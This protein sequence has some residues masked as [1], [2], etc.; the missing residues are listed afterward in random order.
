MQK[1][2][3]IGAR[4]F[5]RDIYY[6]A[7]QCN[8]YQTL[9]EI[10]GFLDDKKDALDEFSSYPPILDSVEN[11]IVSD[12]DIFICALGD[13]QQK[14]KYIQLILDKGGNFISL[15]HPLAYID[16]NAKIGVGCI[17]FPFAGLGSGS[18]IGDFVLIQGSSFVGHDS[19]IGNY[20]R[21]DCHAL[22][23][24]GVVVEDEVTIHTSAVINHK[25]GIGKG[26]IIG[27][28]SFVIRNVKENTTVY[29]NPAIKLK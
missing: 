10:K 12:D 25:V 22:C 29:G 1:L 23:V 27:A 28:L 20:S 14:K 13:V 15:I 8:G 18:I 9:Y 6:L 16:R 17:V 5:G 4:G 3:I 7:T 26:A 24:G 11:Y 21:I 19:K 2:L